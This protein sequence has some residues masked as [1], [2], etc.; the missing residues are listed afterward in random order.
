MLQIAIDKVCL[1]VLKARAFDVKVD[2]VEPDPGS[3][4]SDEDMRAVLEDYG[5][6]PTYAEIKDFID[7]L[8]VDEQL[9]L[10]TLMWIGRGD[11]AAKDWREAR[12]EATR[13]RNEHTAEYLL[14]TPLL[15]DFLETGLS[16]IGISCS[17]A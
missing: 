13:G 9:D 1:L 15:G 14:G 2:V 8:N 10:V 7:S 16:Q 4:P 17:D 12:D 5:D 11:F 3:N 6:D